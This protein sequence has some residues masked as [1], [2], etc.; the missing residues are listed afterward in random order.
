MTT[1]WT[2]RLDLDVERDLPREWWAEGEDDCL[3]DGLTED[4][5]WALIRAA[6]LPPNRTA[7]IAAEHHLRSGESTA[8]SAVD[9]LLASVLPAEKA[10]IT[11]PE[12]GKVLGLGEASS[13]AAARR[14]DLPVLRFGH[15]VVVPVP[16]LRDLLENPP[17]DPGDRESRASGL[18]RV[19]P[20]SLRNP[21]GP[22]RV[23]SQ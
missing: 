9:A 23:I 12:A 17:R 7:V 18:R 22:I 8:Q 15:R 5:R 2:K 3:A 10:T 20:S 19:K 14:G 21:R 11:V 6:A 16:A 1:D 4:E 13:Y